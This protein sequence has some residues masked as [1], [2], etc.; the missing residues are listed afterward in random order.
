ML[1]ALSKTTAVR[2][3]S[4]MSGNRKSLQRRLSND[5]KQSLPLISATGET[6]Q[7]VLKAFNLQA[8]NIMNNSTM[9]KVLRQGSIADLIESSSD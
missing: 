9:N 3:G 5:V 2:R 1:S 6:P 8:K 7:S 4:K